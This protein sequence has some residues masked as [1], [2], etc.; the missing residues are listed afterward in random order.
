M[1]NQLTIRNAQII[2]RNFAGKATDYNPA[3]RRNFSVVIDNEE[4][5]N[6]LM[7]DGWNLKPLKKRDEHDEQHWHLPVAVNYGPY[8]PQITLVCGD[9]GQLLTEDNVAMIDWA[10]ILKVDLTIRPREYNVAGRRGIKAYL[11]TMYVTIEQDD[12]AKD[13]AHLNATAD[14]FAEE[15]E[16]PF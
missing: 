11:K 9:N 15:E 12:L 8:P 6:N 2:F 13:Y 7:A 14:G 3:G 10:D 1:T 5:A 16:T 4:T